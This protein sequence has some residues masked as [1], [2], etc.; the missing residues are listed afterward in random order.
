MEALGLD[1]NWLYNPILNTVVPKAVM[2]WQWRSLHKS[3]VIFK[4]QLWSYSR[5]Q[6]N[7][8]VKLLQT[9]CKFVSLKQ[10]R[11]RAPWIGLERAS[12][13]GQGKSSIASVLVK[14]FW[15]DESTSEFPNKVKCDHTGAGLLKG[16]EGDM[17]M[18]VDT[19]SGKADIWQIWCH[20]AC[21]TK[22]SWGALPVCMNTWRRVEN[23]HT[24]KAWSNKH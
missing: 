19:I 21:R 8:K 1:T 20:L 22:D 18:R 13:A 2:I 9:L 7:H 6:S 3:S 12:S 4:I 15:S 10:R 11:P 16:H 23:V 5:A 14:F 17:G 24:D